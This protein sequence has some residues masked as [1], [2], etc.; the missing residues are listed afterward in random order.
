MKQDLGIVPREY[1]LFYVVLPMSMLVKYQQTI[2]MEGT[3]PG[4]RVQ[5]T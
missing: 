1:L 2:G 3:H 4:P 5:S